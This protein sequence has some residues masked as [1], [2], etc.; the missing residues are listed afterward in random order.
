MSTYSSSEHAVIPTDTTAG[1]L[2]KLNSD[3]PSIHLS[4]EVGKDDNPTTATTT[5]LTENISEE[6]KEM[7]KEKEKP[8]AGDL[9]EFEESLESSTS[10]AV[11]P[12]LSLAVTIQIL[13]I[14]L[15]IAEN[16]VLFAS[17]QDVYKPSTVHAIPSNE[18]SVSVR[19]IEQV[20]ADVASNAGQI[21]GGPADEK[22]GVTAG[23]SNSAI[24]YAIELII[25][26]KAAALIPMYVARR[27]HVVLKY[28]LNVH[29]LIL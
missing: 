8:L 20:V 26:S 16:S 23:Y 17:V 28:F 1:T 4:K 21:S 12:E 5:K 6:K 11:V 19:L 25:Q 2:V 13:K 10:P 24:G 22:K 27:S 18:H 3:N 9:D 14:L 7:G 29:L 15:P